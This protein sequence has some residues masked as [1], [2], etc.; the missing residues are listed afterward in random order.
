[1]VHRDRAPLHAGNCIRQRLG[2][3]LLPAQLR[4]L[5]SVFESQMEEKGEK[6]QLM[7]SV[8]SIL[9]AKEDIRE[10]EDDEVDVSTSGRLGSRRR[11]TTCTSLIHNGT[12][13][14]IQVLP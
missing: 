4:F 2:S 9:Y 6:G 8:T 12:R 14:K 13:P 5:M 10:A 1:M 3:G 11:L 7:N